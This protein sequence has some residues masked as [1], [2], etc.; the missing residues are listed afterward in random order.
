MVATSTRRGFVLYYI[1]RVGDPTPIPVVRARLGAMPSSSRDCECFKILTPRPSIS[2]TPAA[3]RQRQHSHPTHT[4]VVVAHSPALL[5]VLVSFPP[6]PTLTPNRWSSTIRRRQ[7]DLALAPRKPFV[8]CRSLAA[9]TVPTAQPHSPACPPACHRSH[10]DLRSRSTTHHLRYA[11]SSTRAPPVSAPIRS[12][13][14]LNGLRSSC[15]RRDRRRAA[16]AEESEE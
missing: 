1:A 14:A 16:C 3:A 5:R 10:N 4:L 7:H 15:Q 2:Y 11:R 9:H 6:A 12:D 13:P 8:T